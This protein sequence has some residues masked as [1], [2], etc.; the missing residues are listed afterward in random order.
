MVSSHLS[1]RLRRTTLIAAVVFAVL[2]V[3][4]AVLCV[5]FTVLYWG[6][7]TEDGQEIRST[8]I[9]NSALVAGALITFGLTTWRSLIAE[10][11]LEAAQE[12][13]EIAQR[14]LREVRYQNA[15]EM[16]HNKALSI[17]VGA[18]HVLDRLACDH[19]TEFHVQ[20]MRLFAA[21]ARH[22]VKYNEPRCAARGEGGMSA[23]TEPREDIQDIIDSLGRRRT[24]EER[25]LERAGKYVLDLRGADLK[26]VRFPTHTCLRS[27]RLF[28]A[29]FFGV[30]GLTQG[31]LDEADPEG[32]PNLEDA[33][34]RETKLPLEWR[35]HPISSD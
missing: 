24:V 19:P 27:A 7:I 14:S 9:R 6:W 17:R 34:D 29:W 28:R 3:V 2:C 20:I 8:V 21:F 12:Q 15:A 22:P 4:F 13:S 18:I 31:Q 23:P 1:S 33:W 25:K 30:E 10:K 32:P 26:K 5:V 16:L 11:Q 35:R